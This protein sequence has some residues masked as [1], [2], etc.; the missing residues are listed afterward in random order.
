VRLKRPVGTGSVIA[1]HVV[2]V[3]VAAGVR[4]P[5]LAPDGL[6]RAPDQAATLHL[7]RTNVSGLATPAARWT[8]CRGSCDWPWA[9]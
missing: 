6:R 9:C 7:L 2:V 8:P 3:A 4:R 1:G 5:G